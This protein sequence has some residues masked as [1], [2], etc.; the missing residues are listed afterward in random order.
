MKKWKTLSIKY[1]YKTPYGNLREDRCK[2]PNGLIIDD[3]HVTEY[4]DWVDA[5]VLTKDGKIVLVEQYR[6]AGNDFF[7]EIPGGKMEK[8]ESYEAGILRE[9]REE[10]GYTSA[11]GA[12]Q[13]GKFMVN[14]AV[15]N[16]YLHIFLIRDA[17]KTAEQHLDT[18]EDIRIRLIDFNNMEGL[19]ERGDIHTQLFTAAACALAKQF[20]SHSPGKKQPGQRRAGPDL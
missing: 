19:I 17:V 5:V 1:L 18:T 16:N 8:G 7:L 6:H 11:T 12:I 9:V 14:P 13:L 4:D 20:L 3:Y 2:L 10:T 15:Q